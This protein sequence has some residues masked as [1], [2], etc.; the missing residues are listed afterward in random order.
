MLYQ[1]IEQNKRNTWI[2]LGGFTALLLAIAGLLSVYLT[3]WA[4]MIFLAAGIIYMVYI[5]FYSTKHLMRIT[6]AVEINQENV[7]Q[8]YEMVEE[9][10]LAAGIPMPKVYAI[11]SNIPNAFA[12]GR[13]PEHASLAVTSG[14]VKIMNHDELLGVIG[15]EISH[16]RN[17]DLRVTTITSALSSFIYLAAVYLLALGW[18]LF[19]MDGGVVTKCI[20]W[21]FGSIALAVGASLFI[22]ALPIAK[23]LNLSM[24]RQREYLA[25]IG[26]V[27]LTRNPQCIVGALKK[28]EAIEQQYQQQKENPMVSALAFNNFQ[29]KHW[30]TN[31]ISDHPTLD[32]RIDRLE[33]TADLPK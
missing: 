20:C 16:I 24:S 4:G 5:Y 21:F 27:D 19:K 7:P 23:L 18:T 3:F 28:L 9:M 2:V 22:V 17:Y 25:D 12:T 33:H 29:V 30:W 31:L 6:H 14:L 32:R 11:P 1:Q 26:S 8:L 13:D 10:S 15:H